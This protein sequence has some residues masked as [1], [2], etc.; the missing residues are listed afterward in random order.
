MKKEELDA[1]IETEQI[2]KMI[3][4]QGAE[5]FAKEKKQKV[6]V[7][8]YLEYLM[9]QKNITRKEMIS[10]LNLEESYGRKLFGGQRTPTR[11]ILIQSAF[12][13]G[14]NMEETQRILEIGQR[15]RLYPRV[16]YDA[17]IIYG[18]EKKMTLDEMNSFLEEIGEKPLL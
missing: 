1:M 7:G 8:L 14:L 15:P 16:R 11:K 12:I 2:V 9:E 5:Y 10:K 17:A 4:E 6:K 18:L 3:K 13:L